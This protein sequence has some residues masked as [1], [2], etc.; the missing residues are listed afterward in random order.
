MT[1]SKTIDCLLDEELAQGFPAGDPASLTEP[2]GDW[3]DA[4]GCCCGPADAESAPSPVA[5]AI[6][7]KACCGGAKAA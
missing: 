6:P 3:R 2:A 5:V 4:K 1:T 7:A